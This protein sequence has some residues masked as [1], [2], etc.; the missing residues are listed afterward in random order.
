MKPRSYPFGDAYCPYCHGRG[1]VYNRVPYG[2][3]WATESSEIC[4]C[5]EDP[6]SPTEMEEE[7]MARKSKTLSGLLG[8]WRWALRLAW[9]TWRVCWNTRSLLG[10]RRWRLLAETPGILRRSWR[11]ARYRVDP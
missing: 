3:G 10:R 6:D 5:V 8:R 9:G 11:L 1:I 2:E 4:D 7:A